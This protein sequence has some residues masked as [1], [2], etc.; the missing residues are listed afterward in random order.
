MGK[1]S[2]ERIVYTVMLVVVVYGTA[3]AALLA[4]TIIRSELQI[5]GGREAVAAL[6]RPANPAHLQTYVRNVFGDPLPYA[7]VHVAGRV[8]QADNS[9]LIEL[10][11]L[12]P[13]R[14]NMTVFAGGYHPL[15]LDVTL[16][17]GYNSPILKY[18]TGLWPEYFLVDF[19]IY[20]SEDQRLMGIC[21]FANGSSESVY[22]R[23]ARLLSPQGEVIT[24]FLH[25]HDGF[26]YYADLSTKIK[27]VEEPQKALLWPPQTWQPGEF[28]P[29]PGIFHFGLYTL[30]VH[31]GS[32]EEH[33]LGQYQ[34]VQITDHLDYELTGNPHSTPGY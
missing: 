9:G 32:E 17:P 27:V 25:D 1:R 7:V 12:H 10:F 11:D 15:T 16:E 18:D 8:G 14:Y 20:Y 31:F 30:E 5:W 23:H 33:Q 29:I 4:I 2:W 21:G 22:I 3:V 6:S 34:I 19:H 24:D 28:P 26:S 13:G